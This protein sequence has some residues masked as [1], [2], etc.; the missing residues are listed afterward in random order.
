MRPAVDRRELGGRLESWHHGAPLIKAA[1]NPE[2]VTLVRSLAGVLRPPLLDEL[3]RIVED[4]VESMTDEE[5]AHILAAIIAA[6]GGRRCGAECYG[7]F[8]RRL[9]CLSSK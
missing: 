2:L 5:L 1:S 4:R 6:G 7:R 9:A 3:Q 8:W